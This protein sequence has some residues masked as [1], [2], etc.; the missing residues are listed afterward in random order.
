MAYLRGI[1][2]ASGSLSLAGGRA[3]LE[4]VV[5]PVDAAQLNARLAEVGLPAAVRERR[6]RGVVTWKG[7]ETILTFL[8]HAGASS[9][10]LE[11]ESRHVT[12]SLRGHL[13]RVLNAEGANLSRAVVASSR[14]LERIDRLERSGGLARL[15]DRVRAVARWRVDAPEA[16]FGEIAAGLGISRAAVQRAFALLEAADGGGSEPPSGATAERAGPMR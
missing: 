15:P 13:N 9:G 12:R 6:G 4:F 14:Q 8:R 3:H 5:P 1:F 16:T 2:L 10:A 11:L 7:A